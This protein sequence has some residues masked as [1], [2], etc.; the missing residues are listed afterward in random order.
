MFCKCI[1]YFCSTND[2]LSVDYKIYVC[3][4]DKPWEIHLVTRCAH[5]IV[6]MQWDDSSTKLL[7]VLSV[8]GCEIWHMKVDYL[9]SM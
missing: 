7:V 2:S 3:D 1:E 6:S 8:G 9:F 4:I 5:P